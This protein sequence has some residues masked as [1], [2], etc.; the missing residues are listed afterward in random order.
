[1]CTAPLE[2]APGA[3]LL[4]LGHE[5]THPKLPLPPERLGP[6]RSLPAPLWQEARLQRI[7]PGHGRLSDPQGRAPGSA[8]SPGKG[9]PSQAENAFP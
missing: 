7:L 2:E 4:Y 5:G 9:T 8:S 3:W 1:M 6:M